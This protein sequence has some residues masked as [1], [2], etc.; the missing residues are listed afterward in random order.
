[1]PKHNPAVTANGKH[2]RKA[3]FFF[4]KPVYLGGYPS[5]AHAEA[6][7]EEDDEEEE[8]AENPGE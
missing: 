2:G 4:D 3:E 6:A 5:R 8:N 7:G 1:M